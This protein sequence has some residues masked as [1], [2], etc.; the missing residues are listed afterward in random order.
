MKV[1]T[2]VIA[3]MAFE[4]EGSE[5]S[6]DGGANSRV[7]V[8]L[9]DNGVESFLSRVRGRASVENDFNVF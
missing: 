2:F 1:C 3:R 7:D 9:A 8:F 6:V 4:A 5:G